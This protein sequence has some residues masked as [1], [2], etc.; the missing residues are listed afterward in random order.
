MPDSGSTPEREGKARRHHAPNYLAL[1]VQAHM[2]GDAVLLA[3][4]QHSDP[5]LRRVI[6]LHPHEARDLYW[7]GRLYGWKPLDARDE[8]VPHA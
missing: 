2:D 4:S 3:V 7:E 5:E 8:A 1:D 6:A